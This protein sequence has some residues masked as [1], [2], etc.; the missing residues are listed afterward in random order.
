MKVSFWP[1]K[2][3][4]LL[5]YFFLSF[6]AFFFFLAGS[7]SKETLSTSGGVVV[8]LR[9]RDCV[10]GSASFSSSE[11]SSRAARFF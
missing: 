9:L 5:S 3:M 10:V 7:S 8:C 1:F 2:L 11:V 4:I 6:F